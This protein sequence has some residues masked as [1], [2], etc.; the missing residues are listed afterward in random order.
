MTS[1]TYIQIFSGVPPEITDVIAG[2]II[3]V[4]ALPGI[5]KTLLLWRR[6]RTH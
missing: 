3:I 2:V 6:R 5:S 4:L 1:Q